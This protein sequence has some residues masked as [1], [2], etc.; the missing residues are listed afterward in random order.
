MKK[1]VILLLS[2]CLW[3]S[4][5]AQEISLEECYRKARESHPLLAAKAGHGQIGAL[6]EQNLQTGWY[7]SLDL[8]ASVVHN[9]EVADLSFIGD[10]LP[11]A[12]P[13]GSL[14]QTPQQTYRLSL[15]V[16]QTLY[17]GGSIQAARQLENLTTRLNQQSEEVSIYKIYSQINQPYFGIL[18]L[19]AQKKQLLLFASEL[20]ERITSLEAAIREGMLLP[21]QLDILQAERLKLQQQIRENELQRKAL[22][23][24]LARLTGIDCPEGVHLA[25]PSFP[26]KAEKELARPELGLFD[27]QQQQAGQSRKLLQ[28]QRMPKA[29]AFATLGYGNPPGN[30][31][32]R[33]EFDAFYV[34]G[35]GVQWKITDWNTTKRKQESL[36]IRE[37]MVDQYRTD[38]IRTLENRM[39]S[40]SS[41]YERLEELLLTDAE[42][43]RLWEKVRLTAAS[44]LENGVIT[45]TDYLSE[46]NAEKQARLLRELHRIQLLK[47]QADLAEL[48]GQIPIAK[49]E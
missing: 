16:K 33:D 8:N 36:L 35:A 31:F 15:D 46:L 12:L 24:I 19:D 17:D 22:V 6:E 40:R 44:E 37:E 43:I 38:F 28:T 20:E 11:V 21:R 27:Y 4:A 7:P 13:P 49:N 10:V 14:P 26:D 23:S 39:E 3:L 5:T 30:N 29:F 41:E 32:F 47:S 18:L 45:A 48:S 34:L 2:L 1:P 25:V 42:I 9:S